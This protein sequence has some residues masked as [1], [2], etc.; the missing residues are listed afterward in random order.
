[1][2]TCYRSNTK[3]DQRS[4]GMALPSEYAPLA[5]N[6]PAGR[7]HCGA[8]SLSQGQRGLGPGWRSQRRFIR[9]GLKCQAEDPGLDPGCPQAEPLRVRSRRT[10]SQ[11][12][13]NV[14]TPVVRAGGS[15]VG[16]VRGAELRPP[17][18]WLADPWPWWRV[19]SAWHP[20]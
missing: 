4:E 8:F 2:S 16:S 15:G 10:T 1:M 19:C 12:C 11:I 5:S 7:E 13:E 20:C 18:R 14:L 3:S 6:L 9:K 17:P